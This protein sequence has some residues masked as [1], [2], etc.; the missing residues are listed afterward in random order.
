MIGLL[1]QKPP[2]SAT[3]TLV[4]TAGSRSRPLIIKR[5]AQARRM[6]LSVDP[7]DGGVRLVMPVRASIRAALK[8]VEEHRGWIEQALEALPDAQPIAH[9]TVI[10]VGGEALTIEIG[11]GVR[12]VKRVGA[13]LL[14][15]PPTDLLT[16]RVVRWLRKQALDRLDAETRR[17]AALAGVSIAKVSI[18]D[19]RAR[20]GSCSSSGDIRYSWRLILAPPAVRR[21]VVAHEVAHLVHLDHSAKFK[22]LEA[23][24]YG[25]GVSEAKALLRRAGPRLKRIGRR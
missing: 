9:G 11:D 25:S 6:R 3:E 12:G 15:A 5:M 16:A 21:Y 14:V 4:F 8:W 1:R 22:A 17:V 23:R 24:L 10:E 7:R 18:G 2:A 13:R 19:P 20:W